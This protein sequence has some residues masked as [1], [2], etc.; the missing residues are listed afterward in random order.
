M[1]NPTYGA[2]TTSGTASYTV[3]TG[4]WTI[5]DS[6]ANVNAALA[7]MAFVPRNHNDLDTSITTHI[8]DAAVTGPVDGS[9][10]LNVTALNDCTI[11]HHL[12]NQ[13]IAY[14]EGDLSNSHG[15]YCGCLIWDTGEIITATLTLVDPTYGLPDNFWY[16]SNMLPAPAYGPLP[17]PS[18]M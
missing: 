6:V 17:I 4:I 16:G 13:T 12:T 2:L 11:G 15:G 8:E 18:P 3:G 5:T 10:A 1:A 7:S 14:T 9:I